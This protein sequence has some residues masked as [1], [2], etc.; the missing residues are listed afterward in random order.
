MIRFGDSEFDT[1]IEEI[2]GRFS[3]TIS[4]AQTGEILK[5]SRGIKNESTALRKAQRALGKLQETK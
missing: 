2:D 3:F 1:V 4:D 5:Q